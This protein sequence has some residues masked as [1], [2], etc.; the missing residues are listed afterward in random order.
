MGIQ[1]LIITTQVAFSLKRA[2]NCSGKGALKTCCLFTSGLPCQPHP[3]EVVGA[4]LGQSLGRLRL[5]AL[6]L[7][8][9]VKTTETNWYTD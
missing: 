1:T 9:Q 5:L 8:H 2:L 4:E 6:L 3:A 7:P